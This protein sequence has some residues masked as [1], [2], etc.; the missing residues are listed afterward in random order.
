MT[1]LLLRAAGLA[2]VYLLVMT[3]L[4]PGNVLAAAVFG[5]IAAYVFSPPGERRRRMTTLA[6]PLAT[7]AVLGRTVLDVAIG[8]WRTVRFCLG[9]RG[10]PGFV[11]IP[12]DERSDGDVALWGMLTG[13]AP[14][15]YPVD[16]DEEAGELIVHVLDAGDPDAVRARHRHVLRL[17]H[18]KR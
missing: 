10:S 17:W 14:D 11:K 6:G 7:A 12:R 5:L 2:V 15:E 4:E 8:S 1:A 3:S 16:V 18:R 9:E 13:E